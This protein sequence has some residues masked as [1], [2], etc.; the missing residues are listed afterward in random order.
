MAAAKDETAKAEDEVKHP[1]RKLVAVKV[2]KHFDRYYEGEI[3][4]VEEDELEDL[5]ELKLVEK[6]K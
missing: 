6:T 1:Q 4:G 2:L 3:I 5:N